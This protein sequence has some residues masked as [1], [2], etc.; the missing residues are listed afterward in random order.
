MARGIPASYMMPE[1]DP[2][3]IVRSHCYYH[4]FVKIDDVS[5][6]TLRAENRV[7]KSGVSAGV[8]NED[9]ASRSEIHVRSQE[10]IS[11]AGSKTPFPIDS[12]PS[13]NLTL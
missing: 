11:V 6:T 9:G 13:Q 8:Q 7:G 2:L 3:R 12:N 4:P 1:P 5:L 10:A